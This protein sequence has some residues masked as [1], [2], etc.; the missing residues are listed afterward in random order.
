[1]MMRMWQWLMSAPGDT[2]PLSASWAGPGLLRLP[3][4]G[5]ALATEA[6]ASQCGTRVSCTSSVT[7]SPASH[8][9]DLSDP[10]SCVIWSV[11]S[12]SQE[13]QEDTSSVILTPDPGCRVQKPAL[14]LAGFWNYSISWIMVKTWTFWRGQLENFPDSNPF[15]QY[16]SNILLAFCLS[17]LQVNFPEI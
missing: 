2:R 15:S 10:G 7:S 14:A 13:C 12:W 6:G 5:L 11:S 3:G 9:S 1:M 17:I 4:P 8:L 16:Y